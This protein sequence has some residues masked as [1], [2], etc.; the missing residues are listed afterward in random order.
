MKKCDRCHSEINSYITSM[1][2]T[3]DL[4]MDCKDKEIAHPE[5][6]KA[7]EAEHSACVAGDFNYPGI[8]LPNDLS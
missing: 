4:C 3:Q 6:A 2:N 7:V 1:F 5:Y 8:G